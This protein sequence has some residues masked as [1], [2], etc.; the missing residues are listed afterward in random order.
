MLLHH[1]D[2]HL[3]ESKAAERHRASV[4]FRLPRW[5]EAPWLLALHPLSKQS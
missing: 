2:P 4:P 3:K 1:H 5:L